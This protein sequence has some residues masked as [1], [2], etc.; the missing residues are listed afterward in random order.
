LYGFCTT[1]SAFTRGYQKQRALGLNT[2]EKGKRAKRVFFIFGRP[3]ILG[4]SKIFS[5]GCP[6]ERSLVCA[7]PSFNE[8]AGFPE[9]ITLLPC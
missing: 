1:I 2:R 7:A 6:A 4:S 3:A 5:R 9:W 8:K